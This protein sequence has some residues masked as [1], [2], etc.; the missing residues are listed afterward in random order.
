MELNVTLTK[1]LCSF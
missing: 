1:Q